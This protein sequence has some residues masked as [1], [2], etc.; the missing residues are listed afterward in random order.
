MDDTNFALSLQ[1]ADTI[2]EVS[3][4]KDGQAAALIPRYHEFQL[5]ALD[6]DLD[7]ASDAAMI[8]LARACRWIDP[9]LEGLN[10][11]FLFSQQA[12][13]RGMPEDH[14]R[15]AMVLALC[16]VRERALGHDALADLLHAQAITL[17]ELAAAQG[18]VRAEEALPAIVDA[19]SA[20]A[21]SI[22]AR[23]QRGA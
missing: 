19:V 17:T 21:C 7:A 3:D 4:G 9:P 6:G 2:D 13:E 22:A 16:A 23:T 8:A 20:E 18:D 1:L 11:A 15:F 12:N 5:R 10:A 14:L